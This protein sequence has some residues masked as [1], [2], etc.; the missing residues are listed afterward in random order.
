[1]FR[2]QRQS[3]PDW[4]TIG[5]GDSATQ[6][7]APGKARDTAFNGVLRNLWKRGWSVEASVPSLGVNP[8]VKLTRFRGHIQTTGTEVSTHVEEEGSY[9]VHAGVRAADGRASE[10]HL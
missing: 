9:T 5:R 7:R 2:V 3:R 8:K 4:A 1:M 10:S 6:A